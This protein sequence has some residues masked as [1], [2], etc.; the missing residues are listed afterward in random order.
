MSVV[1]SS[2]A[3]A[4]TRAAHGAAVCIDADVGL[5][6]RRC[7]FALCIAECE[8]GA[9]Y[10]QGDS[11]TFEGN[12]AERCFISV[13]KDDSHGEFVFALCIGELEY[14]KSAVFLC[15]P[16]VEKSADSTVAL[17]A[18]HGL[19]IE[20]NFSNCNSRFG[21]SGPYYRGSSTTS[22]IIVVG[23]DANF[24][25]Y[26]SVDC[27]A[28][29]LSLININAFLYLFCAYVEMRDI[30]DSIIISTLS[31]EKISNYHVHFK[32][33]FGNIEV[34]GV[35]PTMTSIGIFPIKCYHS[36]VTTK[37]RIMLNVLCF[38]QVTNLFDL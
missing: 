20:S 1:V 35:S 11:L 37:T 15:G 2:S 36:N 8:G 21:T 27:D 28:K 18:K 6:V 38:F 33:C 5:F 26:F 34:D 31:I 10:F 22:R 4:D 23:G 19:V 7:S 3:F 12:C 32:N 16:N 14:S 25:V 24:G 9:V 13:S 29:K 30:E 17:Q